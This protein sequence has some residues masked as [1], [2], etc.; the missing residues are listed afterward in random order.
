[1]KIAAMAGQLFNR[2][3][4]LRSVQNLHM[5]ASR[6]TA[7]CLALLGS[8]APHRAV[9]GREDAGALLELDRSGAALFAELPTA[10]NFGICTQRS[11]KQIPS[12]PEFTCQLPSKFRVAHHLNSIF[13][14]SCQFQSDEYRRWGIRTLRNKFI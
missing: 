8:A 5:Y 13:W 14:D 7:A 1:M 11:P 6:S 4:L 3:L 10:Q 9:V 12:C 2:G